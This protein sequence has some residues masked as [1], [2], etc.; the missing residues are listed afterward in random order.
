SQKIRS[1]MST[2]T[3]VAYPSDR[4]I[5]FTRTLPAPRELVWQ[6]WTD[7]QHVVHWWGPKGFT[8]TIHEMNVRAGGVWRLTMH[9]PD[10]TNYPNIITFLEVTPPT[11]L[12]YDHGDDVDPKLFHVTTDFIAEGARTK[13]V[14]RMRF[15]TAAER[16][17][18]AKFGVEG[19]NTSMER[20]EEHLAKMSEPEREIVST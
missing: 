13:I 12:V 2:K 15:R 20:L 11:R 10:G 1:I 18:R 3:H 14:K 8:N 9:G 17:E 5:I 4:E 19:H 16:D 6:A 7:P